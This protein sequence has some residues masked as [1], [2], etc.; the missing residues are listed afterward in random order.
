MVRHFIAIGLLAVSFACGDSGASSD[1]GVD[2]APADGAPGEGGGDAATGGLPWAG[3]L[4][5]SRAID[6]SQAGV[7]GGIPARTT[8]CATMSPGATAA[9]INAAIQACP[10]GQVVTLGAGTFDISDDGIVMKSGV[11]VR[12]AGAD[13]T[14][15]VFSANNF[16]SNLQAAICFSG[17]NDWSGASNTQP[18]GANAADWTGGYTRGTTDI[19][20][21]NVGS[22]GIKVGQWLYLDQAN[23]TSPGADFFVC[24][25]T[26]AS[27][28]L[29]GG[30]GGRIVDSV[31]RSQI[32]I[33]KVTAINGSTYTISPG[34]YSPNWRSSQSPGAWWPTTPIQDAGLEDVSVD[35]T[36]AGGQMNVAIY[37]AMNDWVRGVRLVRTCSCQR[38]LIQLGMTAHCTIAND[39]FYGTQGQSE[40]YGVEAYGGA[41]NLVENNLFQHVVAPVV[42]QQSLGSVFSYNYAINDTYADGQGIHW[43]ADEFIQHN[44]GIEFNLYE[45]NIGPGFGGDVFHGNQL[46]NTLFRNYFLGTDPGRADNTTVMPLQSYVRYMNVVGNVLGTPG[47]TTTY[48]VNSG[49]G[50]TGTVY[51]LGAGN[52][53]GAVTVPDDPLVATTLLRWGNYDTSGGATKFDSSEVPSAIGKYAN[54][55]PSSESLPASFYLAGKPAWWPSATPW[56][57]IG[58]DVTSGD[59]AGLNGHASTIPAEACFRT[60]MGGPADGSGGVLGFS[61]SDCYGP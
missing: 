45:G 50:A 17:T 7:E 61:A 24:D 4:D 8:S 42:V 43:M 16:C 59:L 18:G 12:G 35:A 49:I 46:M 47:T 22:A 21:A 31:V 20:L 2:G 27:C 11:T 53:E 57:P 60:K 30:N 40:N 25:T 15:L 14:L 33:V 34:L 3:I 19:T 9:Q 48:Q 44:A 29:E 58:P 28:S 39:Y 6:W 13:K 51:N 54:A 38:S 41:D 1:G 37:N 32:Q 26:S 23:D 36:N 56:P 55:I 5:P 52:T 10:D